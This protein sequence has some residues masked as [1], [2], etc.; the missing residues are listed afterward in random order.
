MYRYPK[1]PRYGLPFIEDEFWKGEIIATEKTDGSLFRFTVYDERY[2][3]AYTE[4]VLDLEPS[5]GDV[6]AGTSD[7]TRWVIEPTGD[8]RGGKFDAYEATLKSLRDVDLEEVRTLH[9]EYGP[10]V[11][12]GEAMTS[13][14][15]DYDDEV[16]EILGFDVYSPYTAGRDHI[17]IPEEYADTFDPDVRDSDLSAY[18]LRWDGFLDA[19]KAFEAFEMIG[20]SPMHTS[21]TVVRVDADEI[22]PAEMSI[23]FSQYADIQ[24]EGVVFRN[25]RVNQRVKVRSDVFKEVKKH[26]QTTDSGGEAP[27]AERFIA[28]YATPVRIMKT[29][30][31]IVN[32]DG[33]ELTPEIINDTRHRVYDDIWEEEWMT[34][35]ERPYPIEISNIRQL[36]AR[37]T[38]DVVK[39]M[40]AEDMTLNPGKVEKEAPFNF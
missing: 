14:L 13:H 23:P 38:A 39:M 30:L 10:L 9:D 25:P 34:I 27:P 2:S 22:E 11:W 20:I 31:K 5:D 36:L 24:A 35:K 1:V 16:P 17:G 8:I 18:D 32:E 15:I 40:I 21:D 37:K 7:Y 3:D 12:F 26:H 19:E 28:E 6:V 29:V 33:Q 4:E